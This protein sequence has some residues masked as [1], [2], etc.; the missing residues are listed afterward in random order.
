MSDEKMRILK[1]IEEKKITAEEGAKLLAAMDTPSGGEANG[2]AHWLKVRVYDKGSDKAK[3]RVTVPLTLLKIA[4]RLGG[5]FS[6]M[7]P[8]EAK[9]QMA[10]KGIKLD[11]ESF[12]DIERLFDQFAVNGQYKLV[13]VEDDESGEK[14]E[15]YVE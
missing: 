8:D 6:V 14:V 1:M 13:D 12:E 7:M 9:K 2:R 3:V 10:E 15:V 4:G 11:A 5:K